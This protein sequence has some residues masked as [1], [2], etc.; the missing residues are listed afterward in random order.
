MVLEDADLDLT[1][2]HIVSGAFAYSGQRC[3]AIKRV[4]VINEVADTLTEK[5][6]EEMKK[7]KVGNPMEVDEA[8]DVVPLINE[9]AA[10][11]VEGLIKEAK[12]K[13]AKLLC[14]GE[15]KEI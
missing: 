13:G 14:G 4:M 8:L 10:D 11:F 9:G 2:N 15:E 1:A 5:I 12:E 6:K 3:T 7:L